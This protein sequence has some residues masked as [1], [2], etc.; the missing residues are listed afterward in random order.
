MITPQQVEEDALICPLPGGEEVNFYQIIPLYRDEMEYKIQFGAGSLLELYDGVSFVVDPERPD[1]LQEERPAPT[2]EELE[3]LEDIMDDAD[4]H[5]QDLWK[6]HLPVEEITAYNHMAIYLRWCLEHSLMSEAF[7]ESYPDLLSAFAEKPA[8]T[9]LRGFIR[10]QLG[11]RLLHSLFGAEGEAF[12]RYYYGRGNAP[13]F[14][15]DIDDYALRRF[16]AEQYFSEKYQDE[17]Y[18]FLPFDETYYQDMAR[19][20]QQRWEGFKNYEPSDEEPSELAQ[21]MMQYLGCDCEYFP[22][23]KDDDPITAAYSYACRRGMEEGFLPVL[24]AVDD[25]LWETLIFNSDPASDGAEEYGFDP[26]QVAK[27]RKSVLSAPPR[28]GKTVLDSRASLP[29]D[30]LAE[31]R[32]EGGEPGTRFLSY[33]DYA[34]FAGF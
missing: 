6:K 14:P 31:E 5:L 15:S 28:D 27:Y 30:E 21:A 25:G 9:D 32:M 17:T 33:W 16:G 4:W 3:E 18:L 29:L 22:P 13:Y 34:S 20:M 26:V 11:G 8:G 2:P 10:D 7:C 24:V 19:L 12:S 23:M 1:I